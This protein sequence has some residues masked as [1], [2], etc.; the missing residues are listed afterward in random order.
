[1]RQEVEKMHTLFKNFIKEHREV[2]DIEQVPPGK[3]LCASQAIDL[4]LV[5]ELKRSDDYLYNR[6]PNLRPLQ[7]SL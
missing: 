3:H 6:E 4:R 5:D 2:V 1:M 7:N